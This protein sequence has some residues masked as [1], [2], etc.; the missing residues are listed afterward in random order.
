MVEA[1]HKLERE[2]RMTPLWKVI[3]EARAIVAIIT[4]KPLSQQ[5]HGWNLLDF[6]NT[7]LLPIEKD[8]AMRRFESDIEAVEYVRLLAA[9]GNKRAQQAIQLH[10]LN[11][12]RIDQLRADRHESG[13]T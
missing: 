7:G 6:D 9:R 3:E 5:P 8:D 10:D 11:Q 4:A 13:G 1:S 2:A 12:P